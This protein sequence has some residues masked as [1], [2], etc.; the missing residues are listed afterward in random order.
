MRGCPCQADLESNMAW[1]RD[2]AILIARAS[3]KRRSRIY[4]GSMRRHRRR[5]E[6]A[7]I[8]SI[9][10]LHT[11]YAHPT[12]DV[13][14]S[15]DNIHTSYAHTSTHMQSYAYSEIL[16]IRH[17]VVLRIR[18]CDRR[19]HVILRFWLALLIARIHST[20]ALDSKY[21]RQFPLH[22]HLETFIYSGLGVQLCTVCSCSIRS[23]LTAVLRAVQ[24]FTSAL[25]FVVTRNSGRGRSHETR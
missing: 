2:R 3:Q 11:S 16:R 7:K 1:I 21:I 9:H 4:G 5:V 14:T 20:C 12:Q 19:E 22:V 6:R 10:G 15:D 24:R 18:F 8:L 17:T 23:T 25:P 13:R